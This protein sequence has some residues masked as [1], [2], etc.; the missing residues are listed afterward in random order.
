MTPS[1][2][3]IVRCFNEAR[4][5]GRLLTGILEQSLRGVEIVVVD[6]GSTDGTLEV[7]ARYPT[8]VVRIRPQDFS[9]G[10]ALNVGCAASTGELLVLASA[11]VYP[12][13]T[14][15]L[16]RLLAPFEDRRV[17][18]VYGKQQ[19][20][21][22]TRYSEHQV[23]ARWF[24][25]ERDWDQAHFFCN[26][27]NAALRRSLW[28]AL[29]YDETLTGLEDLDMGKRL[30]D[31]GHRIAYEPAA[32][33]VHVHEEG[34]RQ[35]LNRYRREAIALKRITPHE[36]FRLW[37]F[38]RLF[39]ANVVADYFHAWHDGALLRNL[40]DIPLFRLMQHWGAY[41]GSHQR[42]PVSESLKQRFYYPKGLRRAHRPDRARAGEEPGGS[43]IDYSRPRGRE[44]G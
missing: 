34:Y 36:H 16:E 44:S 17:G 6:S 24:P 2:S 5:I 42:G 10:H 7:V 30:K 37:D 21:H 23:F 12:V 18:L 31:A 38:L 32:A 25:D 27:A 41:T 15:W 19:G 4:H 28:A 1:V 22:Q 3:V 40:L 8:R 20:D 35:I 33:I 13:R 29:R 43:L 11:H 14:D 9:F 39:P 26:N